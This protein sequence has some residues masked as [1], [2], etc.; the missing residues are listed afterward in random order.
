MGAN[1]GDWWNP[2]NWSAGG[3]KLFPG[4]GTGVQAAPGGAPPGSFGTGIQP[5]PAEPLGT[6][7]SGSSKPPKE[8]T[9]EERALRLIEEYLAELSK[10]LDMND[11]AVKMVLDQMRA[12]TAQ[13]AANAG[14]FG[15]YSNNMAEQAYAKGYNQL[16]LQ[17]KGL[18]GSA[19][20]MFTGAAQNQRDFEHGQSMD[21]WKFEQ[22][23]S[24]G[25]KIG[26]AIG[27]V[28]GAILGAFSGDIAG[29]AQAGFQVGSGVGQ[30][31][32][33]T[34]PPRRGY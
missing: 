25:A 6:S 11:P 32:N 14:I 18:R 26:G 20:G 28:G 3:Q 16:D 13:N 34:P 5:K 31:F 8:E 21:L 27:G 30:M 17:R 24:P 10:P 4:F 33:S 22:A 23:N 15:G 2:A 12:D 29:G 1:P 19:L 7:Y 9:P